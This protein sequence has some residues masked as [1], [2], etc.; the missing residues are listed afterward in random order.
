MVP[1]FWDPTTMQPP[2]VT[3]GNKLNECA[4]RLYQEK[5]PGHVDLSA[6]WAGWRLRGRWLISPDGQ[7]I[8]PLRLRGILS[9]EDGEKRIH[10][11]IHKARTTSGH[12]GEVV[13]LRKG[14]R[15]TINAELDK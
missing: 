5:V 15:K 6:D 4:S 1:S 8:N 2:C 3:P 10:K 13:E 11:A 7:R 9:R 12:Q 14:L